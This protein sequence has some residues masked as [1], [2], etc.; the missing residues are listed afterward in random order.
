MLPV[1]SKLQDAIDHSR[2]LARDLKESRDNLAE[3]KLKVQDAD[4]VKAELRAEIQALTLGHA[5]SSHQEKELLAKIDELK[6]KLTQKNAQLIEAKELQ[7][8][9]EE[10]KEKYSK[11][12]QTLH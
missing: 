12:I 5:K 11:Q 2:I 10:L 8:T 1:K 9:A 7:R 4:K 6:V 3:E